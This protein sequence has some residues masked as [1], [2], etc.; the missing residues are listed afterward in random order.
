MDDLWAQRLLR[1][2]LSYGK[3]VALDDVES[4]IAGRLAWSA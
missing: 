4:D 3:V 1:G 2:A